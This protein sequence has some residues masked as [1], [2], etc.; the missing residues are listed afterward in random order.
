MKPACQ[1][2]L[3]LHVCTVAQLMK[4]SK[5]SGTF[6]QQHIAAC[7]FRKMSPAEKAKYRTVCNLSSTSMAARR[8]QYK[9]VCRAVPSLFKHVCV[10]E[11]QYQSQGRNPPR[12]SE[13]LLTT[14]EKQRGAMRQRFITGMEPFALLIIRWQLNSLLRPF[15]ENVERLIRDYTIEC[16][17]P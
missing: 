15:S 12:A 1:S 7:D 14:G 10:Y 8:N 2:L 5:S 3:H 17:L 16:K 4:A 6:L 9:P 13:E 11:P